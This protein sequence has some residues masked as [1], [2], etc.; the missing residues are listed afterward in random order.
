M[1]MN[2]KTDRSGSAVGLIGY[3]RVSTSDQKLALNMMR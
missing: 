2:G 1:Q 3:A